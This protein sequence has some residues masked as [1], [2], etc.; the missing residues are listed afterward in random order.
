MLS[1]A[2]RRCPTLHPYW[3]RLWVNAI[4][5]A[6]KPLH[7][8]NNQTSWDMG[9][10]EKVIVCLIKLYE[11]MCVCVC[12]PVVNQGQEKRRAPNCCSSSCR[13]W[14]KNQPGRL[15]RR[16]VPEWSRPSFRAGTAER[17]RNTSCFCPMRPELSECVWWRV[18][19]KPKVNEQKSR[20][21]FVKENMCS[22]K[23]DT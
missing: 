21:S 14:A 11:C 12:S 3:D 10:S 8:W 20:S 17:R 7:Q 4:Y 13:W 5:N 2:L 15:H 9:M 22:V 19:V 1:A 6:I 16:K 18:P 23:S